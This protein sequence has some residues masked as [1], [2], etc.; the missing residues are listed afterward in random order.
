[1]SRSKSLFDHIKEITSVQKQNYWDTLS[2]GD[3]KTWSNYM[4]HRFLSMKMDWVELV[5]ELQKY[6]LKP[7]E[8]YKIYTN[9]L[10]KGKQWLKYIKGEKKMQYADWLVNVVANEMKV[11]KKEAY[12]AVD[13]Y[14]LSEGGILELREI[15]VKW[16]VEPKKLEKAGLN[17]LGSVG[18]YQAGEQ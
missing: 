12:E 7:K 3:K 8:L 10:P 18:M 13:M 4:V 15:C 9:I 5:N 14:M 11:S 16:G 2:D 1:M 6:N 17:V